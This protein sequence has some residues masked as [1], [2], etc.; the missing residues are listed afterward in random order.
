MPHTLVETEGGGPSAVRRERLPVD[1][2]LTC[3]LCRLLIRSVDTP[4]AMMSRSPLV[5]APWPPWIRCRVPSCRGGGALWRAHSYDAF[6]S[7]AG[8]GRDLQGEGCL[9]DGLSRGPARRTPGGVDRQPDRPHPEPADGRGGCVRPAVRTRLP[10]T[11]VNGRQ[12]LA[13]ASCGRHAVPPALR[14][15]L[16][17]KSTR[18]NSSHVAISYAVFCLK[19]KRR[20]LIPADMYV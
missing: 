6:H 14:P 18:L 3:Q 17:R 9:V 13:V 15:G 7:D 10:R 19:K 1:P 11:R 5:D 20:M 8:Q 12:R 4:S 2:P 16:D